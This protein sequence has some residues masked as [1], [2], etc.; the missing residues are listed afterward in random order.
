M[1][2]VVVVVVV[3]VVVREFENFGGYQDGTVDTIFR[4]ILAS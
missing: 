2:V 4:L 1:V 3:I